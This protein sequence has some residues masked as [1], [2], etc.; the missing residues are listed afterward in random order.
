MD[1]SCAREDGRDRT[2]PSPGTAGLLPAGLLPRD[3]H[4]PGKTGPSKGQPDRS[5]TVQHALCAW[6]PRMALLAGHV[7]A[8]FGV[9]V[10]DELAADVHGHA[11]DRAGEL[12][13]IG[14]AHV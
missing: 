4:M 13:Q 14:R 7:H 10:V 11:V 2:R 12:E 6:A 1:G 8:E 3:R 9:V 5:E